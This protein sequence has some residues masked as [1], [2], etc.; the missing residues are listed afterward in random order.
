MAVLVCLLLFHDVRDSSMQEWQDRRLGILQACLPH[1][2]ATRGV[3]KRWMD[4]VLGQLMDAGD[5][6]L[7]RLT[8]DEEG[9]DALLSRTERALL[10]T[11]LGDARA[12]FEWYLDDWP[13][14]STTASTG[15]D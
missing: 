6:S 4:K 7:S 8:V 1:I 5:V 3:W 9:E 14:Y 13:M 11:L 12:A 10:F 15:K 2:I